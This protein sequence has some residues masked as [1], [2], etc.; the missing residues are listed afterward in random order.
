MVRRVS[1]RS[2]QRGQQLVLDDDDT[3]LE[4]ALTG[5]TGAKARLMIRTATM[6][7]SQA[8]RLPKK[9]RVL[10]QRLCLQANNRIRI[11]AT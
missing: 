7:R 10:R 11:E 8:P 9:S 3:D 5:A 2:D 1:G 4:S 6:T